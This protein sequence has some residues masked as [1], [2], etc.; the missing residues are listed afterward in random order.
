MTGEMENGRSI[1]V[2]RKLLPRNSNRATHHAAAIPNI[3]F[4]ATAITATNRVNRMADSVSGSAS[5]QLGANT[6]AERLPRTP[7]SA[8]ST[9]NSTIRAE[10][11]E[12]SGCM[13]CATAGS[14]RRIGPRERLIRHDAPAS[15]AADESIAEQHQK[16]DQ[17]HRRPPPPSRRLIELVETIDDQQ[18]HDFRD[19]RLV[20]GNEYDRTVLPEATCE[21]HGEAGQQRRRSA[22][23]R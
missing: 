7:A 4:N 13:P 6:R 17:Q 23:G 21:G 2:T 19:H 3:M 9:R 15:S 8:A 18:R 11:G 1:S 20:A 14:R 10:C 12:R 22:P 5:R 16:R